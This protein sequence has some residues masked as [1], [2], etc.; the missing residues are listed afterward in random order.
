MQLFLPTGLLLPDPAREEQYEQLAVT[1]P[2]S[3][4]LNPEIIFHVTKC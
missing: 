2:S 4:T 1:C 3:G